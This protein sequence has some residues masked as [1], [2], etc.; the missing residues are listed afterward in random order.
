M[1]TKSN[2]GQAGTTDT[3]STIES[4]FKDSDIFDNN[5]IFSEINECLNDFLRK[6]SE[7]IQQNNE[8]IRQN[9]ERIRQILE[10]KSVWRVFYVVYLIV[11]I[12]STIL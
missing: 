12:I 5:L 10:R 8:R 6:E 11:L 3:K 2:A 4:T 9:N 1:T 7:L